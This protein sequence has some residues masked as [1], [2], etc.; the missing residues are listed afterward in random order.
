MKRPLIWILV[1]V[2]GAVMISPPSTHAAAPQQLCSFDPQ[3]ICSIMGIIAIGAD[4][5]MFFI[6]SVWCYDPA[7]NTGWF[8]FD[9]AGFVCG[10]GVNFTF[11]STCNLN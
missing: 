4:P 10:D 9:C 5:C 7:T 2:V 6:W 11:G 1:L 8:A 3:C